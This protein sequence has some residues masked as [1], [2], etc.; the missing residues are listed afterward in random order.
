MSE[1]AGV[2]PQRK[3]WPVLSGIVPPLA[4][5]FTRRPET[6]PGSWEAPQPGLTVILGPDTDPTAPAMYPGGTGKTQLAAAFARKLWASAKLDLLVWLDAGSR[7]SIVTG[8]ARAL[9][10]IRVAAPAGKPD[11]AASRFLSWLAGTGRR[12][13]VVLDGLTLAE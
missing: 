3:A 12:W 7:D 4:D 6:G 1:R 2:Q 9:A 10:D 13:L 11:V 5:G 8:Y